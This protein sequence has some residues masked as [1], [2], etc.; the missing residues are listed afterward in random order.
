[1][2]H[3]TKVE[4]N[5]LIDYLKQCTM[6]NNYVNLWML[7]RQSTEV[8]KELLRFRKAFRFILSAR[9]DLLLEK[10]RYQT[11]N[12]Y[13]S[14]FLECCS[15]PLVE[16]TLYFPC[17]VSVY[18]NCKILRNASLNTVFKIN[19]QWNLITFC[20]FYKIFSLRILFCVTVMCP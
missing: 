7:K 20:I 12:G 9:D 2:S 5:S 13:Y 1:M 17:S 19:L 14:C 18:R 11:R 6:Q 15:S 8:S 10:E 4:G 16:A 3:S